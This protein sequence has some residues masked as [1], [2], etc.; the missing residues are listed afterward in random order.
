MPTTATAPFCPSAVSHSVAVPADASPL[1]KLALFV[2]PGLLVSVGYMDPGNWATAIEA[3]SRFGYALLFVVVLASFSGMLL[4]SLCSRLGIATGRDLAQLSRER[5]RPGVARGQWL[6]A[7]LSIVATDLAEVLG[8]A[9]AF[10]LLL[11][12][13]IT[14]G[15]V[16][17]AFDTLIVLA[18]QGAN[19]R[20]LEA[21][22][23]GLIATIGACFFVELV[24]IKPYWPDVAAG[25]RPSWDTLG[26]QEPL[27]LAI[28]ILG[29]TVMPHNLYLHS[30]VVQTRV[31]GDDAASKRSA[32]RFSRFDTIGSLSLALLVNA[33]ILILA[34]AAFHGTGHTEVVEIQDAYHLLDPL[35]GGALASF[36][37]GFAL[38]A[39]GQSSTFTG[40]IA[41][42]VVM[43]GFLRAKIPCWQRR[44]I[45][46]G[47]ALIPALLG[48]LWLGEG[49]VGKLLVLSQVLLSLQ[50]PFALWPL[51]RFSG[52][53]GLMGEFVNPPWVS[54]LAWLLFGLISAA[55]LA[56]LYFWFA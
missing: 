7:E 42:Q 35:V 22:V 39:A 48:V 4:Q 9:L 19:F 38:L 12:V 17:T 25:L 41:G 30:S 3:G 43:E 52:D 46:R 53:R 1:R 18:L 44:L 36:L 10:H 45:T 16:L 31:N 24:L 28:G 56:L 11:G 13:S 14:T 32:I 2:G 27:Y 6:L 34:A 54:A 20:R 47:L 51:I 23:L 50:L 8:A 29:A 26:S 55:N 21:I 40:T 37:F 49:A 33:A 5:Y 15:V